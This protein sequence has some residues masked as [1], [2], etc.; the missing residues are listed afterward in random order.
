MPSTSS[1]ARRKRCRN[2]VRTREAPCGR[3][4][5]GAE[6]RRRTPCRG[7]SDDSGGARARPSRGR[8]AASSGA[9]SIGRTSHRHSALGRTTDRCAESVRSGA[10][11]ADHRSHRRAAASESRTAQ[12]SPGAKL[13]HKDGRRVEARCRCV[14][15]RR[16]VASDIFR[17]RRIANEPCNHCF[18]RGFAGLAT[19]AVRI[20]LCA[21]FAT[22]LL[23]KTSASETVRAYRMRLF[24]H[25]E[26]VTSRQKGCPPESYA[27]KAALRRSLASG[28]L[29]MRATEI[30]WGV[31]WGGV[32]RSF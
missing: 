22:T 24:R 5:G 29:R 12:G 15:H 11:P 16:S 2:K 20:A 14:R 30:C 18:P 28:A 8:P 32:G 7:C 3:S 27:S 13:V 17:R 26:M 23:R 19:K 9:E 31:S 25:R 1:Q 4:A 6:K 10:T 21:K